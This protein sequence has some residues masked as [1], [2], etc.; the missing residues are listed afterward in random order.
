MDRELLDRKFDE[1]LVSKEPSSSIGLFVIGFIAAMTTV[2]G[3]ICALIGAASIAN[4]ASELEVAANISLLIGGLL[5]LCQGGSLSL[6][7]VLVKDNRDLKHLVRRVS[8]GLVKRG[9]KPT[10][11]VA[12]Q[13]RSASRP[14]RKRA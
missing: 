1:A 3:L 10:M 9:N 6:L 4:S 14:D 11:N 8:A 7:L 5:I 2:V 13:A 12:S